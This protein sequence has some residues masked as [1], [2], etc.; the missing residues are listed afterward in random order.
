[1]KTTMG[2]I[3][4]ALVLALALGTAA[5]VAAVGPD[6]PDPTEIY[7]MNN[8]LSDVRVFAE[9]A[10]GRLHS[11]GRVARGALRSIDVPESVAADGYRIKV[12]P[13]SPVWSPI[14]DEW[15]IKT[16]VLHSERD[17]R[18]TMWLEADL[19]QSLVEIERG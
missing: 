6:E 8:H 14:A 4:A 7:V 17:L 12:F 18:V 1:M 16:S 2:R 9:D 3:G 19:A 10:D 11:L 13:A 5:P 15:G